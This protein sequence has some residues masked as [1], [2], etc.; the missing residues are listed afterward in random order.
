MPVKYDTSLLPVQEIIKKSNLQHIAIIMDGN[1][2]WAKNKMLPGASGHSA[3]VK[4]L[5]KIVK[6]CGEWGIKYLTV[7]AFSTENWGRKKEEVDFLMFLLGDTIKKEIG[8]LHKQNVRVRFIGDLEPLNKDLKKILYDAMDLTSKNQGLNLQIAFNYGA[9]DEITLAVKKIASEIKAG[10]LQVEDITSELI[11]D[12][13]YTSSIPDPDLLIR[14]GGEQR[15]SNYLLWQ[16]AYTELYVTEILWPDFA[17]KQLEGAIFE[18]EQRERR[19][20]KG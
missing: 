19:Y 15:I 14:T 4:S 17:E 16:L 20:G 9:R 18:F 2:R 8:E 1:R 13:L 12:Y 6:A 5:N 10:S 7:Y 11:S 3:G